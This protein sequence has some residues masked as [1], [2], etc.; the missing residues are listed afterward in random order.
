MADDFDFADGSGCML[1]HVA[2]RVMQTNIVLPF[3]S[4]SPSIYQ[5]IGDH[6][7]YLCY[8]WHIYLQLG[9]FYGKCW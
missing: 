8:I 4:I 6:Q 1:Q 9:D 3:L 5:S 7:A 2:T